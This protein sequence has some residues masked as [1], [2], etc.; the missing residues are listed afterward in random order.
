MA[1]TGKFAGIS[2]NRD[3]LPINAIGLLLGVCCLA[4]CFVGLN[5]VQPWLLEHHLNL[6]ASEI[7]DATGTLIVLVFAVLTG[8]A[9]S[10][11][12]APIASG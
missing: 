9:I 6:P 1:T 5:M 2:L 11:Q 3:V 4:F 7:G 10:R 12:R 8:P